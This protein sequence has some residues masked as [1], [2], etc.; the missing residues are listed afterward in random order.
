[1]I[2]SNNQP[3]IGF[4]V[5]RGLLACLF[6]LMVAASACRQ[7]PNPLLLGFTNNTRATDA[8]ASQRWA[9]PME[10]PGLPNLY[11]VSD[12][13]YR[14]ARPTA[15]GIQELRKLG[16]K[17]VVNLEESNGEQTSVT[18]AGLA[19]EHIPMTAFS[20]KDD[21]M[22]HFLRTIG[23]PNCGP[24]FVHC[25]RGADRTGLMC[26]IYRIALQGWTK[27]DA[28]AE[29]TRGGFRFNHG[30]QNVV[31]YIRDVDP[32]QLKQRAGLV[33]APAESR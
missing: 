15:D 11:K 24:L 26:A 2:L 27:D 12:N 29:M 28:I 33:P 32:S 10:A 30:Y 22:V 14:G 31:N 9:E 21:E 18:D 4:S 16:I 6:F 7:I 19:Y 1:M 8:P 3:W 17:T 23:D 5:I 25:R 13:L 20:V